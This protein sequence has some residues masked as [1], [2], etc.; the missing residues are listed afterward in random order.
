MTGSIDVERLLVESAFR[1]LMSLSEQQDHFL[2]KGRE[3]IRLAAGH[4]LAIANHFFVDPVRAGV[5]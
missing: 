4:D 1:A 2:V 5:C 3:I